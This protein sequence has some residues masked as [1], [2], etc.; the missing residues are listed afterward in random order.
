MVCTPHHITRLGEA[1]HVPLTL[2]IIGAAT[3]PGECQELSS[4]C[5]RQATTRTHECPEPLPPCAQWGWVSDVS[6]DL[7]AQQLWPFRSSQ[8]TPAARRVPGSGGR[9]ERVV[10]DHMEQLL[11]KTTLSRLRGVAMSPNIQREIERSKIR[12]ERNL[13]QTEQQG[14]SSEKDLNET[15]ISNTLDKEF[16]VM[17]IKIAH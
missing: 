8:N 15:E 4:P 2:F 1:P 17:A 12:R 14:K 13:F 6:P 11:H 3:R 16:I 9:G 5:S 10:L 7:P